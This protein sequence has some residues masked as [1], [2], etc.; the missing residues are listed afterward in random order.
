MKEE[1]DQVQNK[2]VTTATEKGVQIGI[3]SIKK[4]GADG[5]EYNVNMYGKQA[6]E[7]I[8]QNLDNILNGK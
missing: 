3:R 6:Q 2:I 1:Y 5:K 4:T 7:Y 8:V